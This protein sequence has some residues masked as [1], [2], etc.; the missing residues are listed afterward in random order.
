MQVPILPLG[1]GYARKGTSKARYRSSGHWRT[2][3]GSLALSQ[4][5]EVCRPHTRLDE[6][7]IFARACGSRAQ[8]TAYTLA[9]LIRLPPPGGRGIA[10]P[11]GGLPC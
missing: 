9:V 7:R 3:A 10:P 5:K 4:S 2:W 1:E 6:L 8:W 11:E